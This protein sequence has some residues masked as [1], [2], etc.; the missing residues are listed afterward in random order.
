M[1]RCPRDYDKPFYCKLKLMDF[2]IEDALVYYIDS[3]L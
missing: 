3:S 2:N 1:G